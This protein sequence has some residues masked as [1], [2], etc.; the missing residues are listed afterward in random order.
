MFDRFLLPLLAVVALALVAL[1]LVWP[2]DLGR[3]SPAPFDAANGAASSHDLHQR[4]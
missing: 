1:A 2:Q 3:P 4:P